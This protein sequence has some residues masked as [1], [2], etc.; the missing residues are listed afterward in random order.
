MSVLPFMYT[1][2]LLYSTEQIY[3]QYKNNK[4]TFWNTL[5]VEGIKFRNTA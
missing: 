1:L 5:T 3:K 4:K 2:P